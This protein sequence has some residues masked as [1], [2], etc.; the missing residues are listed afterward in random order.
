MIVFKTMGTEKNLP[1]PNNQNPTTT[2]TPQPSEDLRHVA[3]DFGSAA[4]MD[5]RVL[6]CS[7]GSSCFRYSKKTLQLPVVCIYLY[8]F[9]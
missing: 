4:E 5:V 3:E 9:F 6:L 2:K 8:F 7:T 1:K